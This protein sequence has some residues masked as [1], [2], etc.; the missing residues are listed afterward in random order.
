MTVISVSAPGKAIVCGEYAVLRGAPAISMAVNRRARVTLTP[1]EDDY[2]TLQ[3]PGYAEGERRFRVRADGCIDWLD[4]PPEDGLALVEHAYRSCTIQ[5]LPGSLHRSIVRIDTREFHDRRSG[6][7]LGLGSSAAVSVALVAALAGGESSGVDC[8]SLPSDV[9]TA[10]QGGYGSGV[11]VAT[12]CRGGVI[13]YRKN[14]GYQSART[15]W[16]EG[17]FYRLLFSGQAADT[18][19]KIRKLPDSG[20][21]SW[22]RLISNAEEASAAWIAGNAGNILD[23]IRSYIGALFQFSDQHDLGVFAA[24]HHA[25]VDL[26]AA[27]GTVYKPCGAGGGDIGIVLASR[28]DDVDAFCEHALEL[29]FAPL[30]IELDEQGLREDEAAS[31]E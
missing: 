16:P 1:A 22:S 30:N 26:A 15:E 7:K 2:C 10:F 24:G 14:D 3:T 31:D 6:D 25:M 28:Q 13:A 19:S 8:W 29:G 12:S 18:L 27:D 21:K 23:A 17:L 4:D 20:S 9:H 5:G 11:D